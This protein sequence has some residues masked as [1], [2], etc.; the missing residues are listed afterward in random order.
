M[1]NFI[2]KRFSSKYFREKVKRKKY[3]VRSI[4]ESILDF[5]QNVVAK[6]FFSFFT[7]CFT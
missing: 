3:E 4:L 2:E 5:G 6:I 7:K 1:L